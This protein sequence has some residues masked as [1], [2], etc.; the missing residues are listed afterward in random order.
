M[1]TNNNFN[2][3]KWIPFLIIF[4]VLFIDLGTKVIVVKTL[5][6]NSVPVD[7]IGSYV[8]LKHIENPGMAFG[9][10]PGGNKYLLIPIMLI[11][12][13]IVIFF[14]K[15]VKKD[16]IIVK[17]S[18]ALILGGALGNFADKVFG[19]IIFNQKLAFFYGRVVDFVDIGFGECRY[20][21]WPTFN[22]ADIAITIGVIVLLYFVLIKKQDEL[23]FKKPKKSEK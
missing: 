6:H 17:C 4:L 14:Y 12:I 5:E 22:M 15:T 10:F 21:R 18:F 1:E 3:K 23:F 20:C 11:A 16:K 7:I 8:R 2:K 13:G 19:D 9:L